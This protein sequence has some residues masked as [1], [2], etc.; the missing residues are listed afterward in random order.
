VV[1][2]LQ[3]SGVPHLF[4]TN[5]TSRPRRLIVEKLR[6]MGIEID[7]RSIITP[8]IAAEQWLNRHVTGEVTLL[9]PEATRED[10]QD[11]EQLPDEREQGAAA[12]VVGDLGE[13]WNYHLLNRAFRLL[14]ADPATQLL[15]LGMTRYWRAEDGLRLDVAPFVKALEYATDKQAVVVGKPSPE[16]FTMC[17]SM[18][19]LES[20]QV[21]MIGDDIRSDVGGAQESGIWGILVRTGKFQESD[22]DSGIDPDVILDSIAQLPDWLQGIQA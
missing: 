13:Q 21:F 17:L 5:T 4:V 20:G 11:V 18:L 14:M 19:G 22:L 16:F 12:V 2:W 3:Q 7:M 15:A 10:L 8:V 9:I 1:S 6:G